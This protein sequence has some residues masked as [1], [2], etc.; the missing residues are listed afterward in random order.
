MKLSTKNKIG[1]IMVLQ[2]ALCLYSFAGVFSKLAAGYDF[3]SKEF[4][5]LYGGSIAV[6]VLYAVIWQQVLKR[7]PLIT[8]YAN[9]AIVVAWGM[10][11]G[12]LL[13]GE[14]VTIGQLFG[15]L[16]IMGGVIVYSI[17]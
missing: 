17:S 6:L 9:K 11:W 12:I 4:I 14:A 1:S 7:V 5:L 13:F 2:A 3:L 16:L 8:A 10:L 15:I